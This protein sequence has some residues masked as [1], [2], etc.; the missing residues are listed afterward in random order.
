MQESLPIFIALA[1]LAL[2]KGGDT[3]ATAHA[4]LIFFIA[5]VAYVPAY[6]SGVPMLR[7]LV[8]LAGIAGL[9]MMA[10]PLI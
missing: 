5:R 2:V 3:T 10:L 1:L 4:A 7:S 6:I 9:V 8:W